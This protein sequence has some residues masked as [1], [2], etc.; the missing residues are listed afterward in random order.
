MEN[1]PQNR[2]KVMLAERM[3][4]KETRYG[5]ETDKGEID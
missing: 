1:K 4:I 2:I 5:K 3:M